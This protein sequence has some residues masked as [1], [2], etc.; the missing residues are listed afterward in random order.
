MNIQP[1]INENSG[2]PKF[3]TSPPDMPPG[4]N[5][6]PDH[7]MLSSDNDWDVLLEFLNEYSDNHNTFRSYCREVERF[8]LWMIVT[9][10]ISISHI[11]RDHWLEYATFLCEPFPIKDWCGKKQRRFIK[12]GQLNSDWRPFEVKKDKAPVSESIKEMP[13][14]YG[15]SPNSAKKSQ[16]TIE[17]LFS[18]LVENNYLNGNPAA[19]R[20]RQKSKNA[21]AR[22]QVKDRFLEN[23]LIDFAVN[24][25]YQKQIE[26]KAFDKPE[27]PYIRA[28]YIIQL[29]VGTGL[30]ISEA[31]G[32]C[33]GDIYC[34]KDDW[35]L[36]VIGKG[37][38]PRE[39]P[40]LPDLVQSTREF[41]QSIGLP[42]STP[43]HAEKTP[44][45][46]R[47]NCTGSISDRRID[48]I[49][50]WAFRFAVDAKIHESERIT[51]SMT[52][53][54]Q[55][56]HGELLREASILE[57]ASAHWLRHSHA[58]YY[59]IKTNNLKETM[60]RLGH[61][62][63]GTTMIYQHIVKDHEGV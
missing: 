61:A 49:L 1:L 31:A 19:I 12:D 48:Q 33:M 3:Y 2:K 35:T 38:K 55:T 4:Y 46:P 22:K 25:L 7:S 57:K 21:H 56:R 27:F 8:S 45:I 47:E 58:T 15:L 18:F 36:N 23:E 63:V 26:A 10:G 13:L 28:R 34:K 53:A 16:K 5:K 59:L 29:L 9:K 30:R 11:K 52:E 42:S 20:R 14:I 17:S 37:D 40:Y 54:D 62:D 43:L 44:L 39:I 60:E 50:K 24:L 51:G 32:H 41:R 6:N